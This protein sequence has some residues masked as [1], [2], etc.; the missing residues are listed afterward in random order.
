M[1]AHH[2]LRRRDLGKLRDRQQPIADRACEHHDDGDRG[3]EDRP[4][5]E[6][7]HHGFRPGG[8]DEEISPQARREPAR[9][10]PGGASAIVERRGCDVIGLPSRWNWAGLPGKPSSF[11][12]FFNQ[13][14]Y[15]SK[16]TF[17]RVGHG[18]I[19]RKC[20]KTKLAREQAERPPLKTFRDRLCM[21]G[22]ARMQKPGL[23]LM[24]A[25]RRCSR[26]PCWF[27]ER[28]Q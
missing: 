6:E 26:R 8:H 9:A 25:P 23:C 2:D 20:D 18:F 11:S 21:R 14:R 4:L 5:N 28:R 1:R 17:R 27:L 12:S 22:R 3:C 7:I 13:W 15:R 16:N 24:S 10:T 19:R